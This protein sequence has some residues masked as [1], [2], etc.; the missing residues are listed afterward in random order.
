MNCT[1]SNVAMFAAGA[2]IGSVVTWKLIR[3]KY[4]RITQEEIK[5]VKERFSNRL[6]ELS[7]EKIYEKLSNRYIKK[8]EGEPKP[9]VEEVEEE[10]VKDIRVISPD[11]YGENGDEYDLLSYTYYADGVL[12]DEMDDPIED[13]EDVIGSEALNTFGEYEPN[14]VFVRNDRTRCDYEILRDTSRYSEVKKLYTPH[15]MGE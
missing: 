14:A 15:K 1:L 9:V 12:A 8:D 13:I 6:K 3:A 10:P 4:E 5:D 7:D 11:E 2:F